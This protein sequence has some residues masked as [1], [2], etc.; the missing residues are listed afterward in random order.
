V[1]LG[2]AFQTVASIHLMDMRLLVLA[3]SEL[4]PLVRNIEKSSKATGIGG[5][6][7]NKGGLMISVRDHKLSMGFFNFQK[8]SCLFQKNL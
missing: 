2:T 8:H 3:R 5:V 6:I 1:Y 4:V 7:G